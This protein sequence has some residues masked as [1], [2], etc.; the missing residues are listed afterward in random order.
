MTNSGRNGSDKLAPRR[1]FYRYA[2]Q[3]RRLAPIGSRRWPIET[4]RGSAC[5]G[6]TSDPSFSGDAL[7]GLKRVQHLLCICMGAVE[8]AGF[9]TLFGLAQRRV[10]ASLGG[11]V[12]L[13]I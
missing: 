7:L 10:Q 4:G 9:Q 11:R 5:P 3:I 6:R 1:R 13:G 8:L 12:A 2:Q